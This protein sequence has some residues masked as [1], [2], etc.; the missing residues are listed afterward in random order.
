MSRGRHARHEANVSYRLRISARTAIEYL[1]GSNNV[2][3]PRQTLRGLER[4]SHP[5]KSREG[6]VPLE[7]NERTVDFPDAVLEDLRSL[8]TGFRLRAYPEMDEFYEA[9]SAWSGFAVGELLATDGADGAIHRVFATFVSEGEEVVIMSP[10]YAMYPVY[11]QMYGAA[12]RTLTFDDQLQLP[13]ASVLAE[14]RPGTR[15]IALVNPNQPIESCFTLEELRELAARC[16][17]HG[18]MLLVDE[19]YYHFCETT[20]APLVREFS[21]V[22][23]ARTLSK[24]FGLAGLRIGYLIAQAPVVQALTA[25]KPIY[26]INNLNAAIA[27]Y[28]LRNPGIMESY[29]ADVNAG[30]EVLVRFFSRLGFS[31]HGKHTNT[32][33]AGF[34]ETV[35]V[36]QLTQ[37]LHERQWVVRAESDPPTPNHLRITLGP[38]DQLHELVSMIENFLAGRQAAI[39]SHD[40]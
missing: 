13:F 8:V 39:S 35:P 28:F 21:N 37:W 36:Q 25:L 33:L 20:A 18:V 26:E 12:V 22:V 4:I 6:L 1:A 32:L 24:A 34:P 23:I 38:P 16:A 14:A 2:I 29:V 7:R 5:V 40:R 10:S 15:L 11:C 3:L 17:E 9:L 27:T 19:A 31:V 30:R